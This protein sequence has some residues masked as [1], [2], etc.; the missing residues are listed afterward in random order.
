MKLD[1]LCISNGKLVSGGA[2]IFFAAFA[3]DASD[4]RQAPFQQAGVSLTKVDTLGADDLGNMTKFLKAD[5]GADAAKANSV[6]RCVNWGLTRFCGCR[7][8][9]L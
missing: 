3:S 9:P 5:F 4:F 6:Q 1:R 2:D 7:E 8:C